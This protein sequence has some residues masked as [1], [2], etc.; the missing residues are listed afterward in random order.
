ML[1]VTS[2][3]GGHVLPNTKKEQETKYK[4]K[5]RRCHVNK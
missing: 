1:Y 5:N 2:L 3:L 4:N